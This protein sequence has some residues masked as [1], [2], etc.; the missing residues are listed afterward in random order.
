[1]LWVNG[2]FEW[3][4]VVMFLFLGSLM[5]LVFSLMWWI[6][7]VWVCGMCVVV[8]VDRIMWDGLSIYS[9]WLVMLWWVI[10]SVCSFEK[11]VRIFFVNEYWFCLFMVLLWVRCLERCL[12]LVGRWYVLMKLVVM[13]FVVV[14]LIGLSRFL[15]NLGVWMCRVLFRCNLWR[16]I[17]WCLMV[18][19][20]L[21]VSFLKFYFCSS[22]FE[23]WFF[24]CLVRNFD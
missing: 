14:E 9:V 6:L 5:D 11:W 19:V 7:M 10:V 24:W 18:E 8:N 1:M 20:L 16:L 21:V 17:V 4:C 23:F 2:L 12:M 22:V 15:C 13:L 3:I